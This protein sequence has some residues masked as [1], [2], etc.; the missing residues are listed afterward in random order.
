MGYLYLVQDT[1]E[2]MLQR[3]RHLD[4]MIYPLVANWRHYVELRLKLICFALA[5]L[6]EDEERVHATHDLRWLWKRARTCLLDQFPEEAPEQLKCIDEHIK[7]LTAVDPNSM[8][9]RYTID[10]EG[11]ASLPQGLQ[12]IGYVELSQT[13]EDVSLM[14]EC[15]LTH[16]KHVTEYVAEARAEEAMRY[17]SDYYY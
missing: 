15:V 11:N 9:F 1:L 6:R 17:A 5:D 3:P 10:K 13:V 14:L 2:Q 8:V 16:V 7:Q 4:T 12:H